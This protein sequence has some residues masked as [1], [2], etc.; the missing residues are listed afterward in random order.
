MLN[1]KLFNKFS[2]IIIRTEE[3][4]VN[5]ILRFGDIFNKDNVLYKINSLIKDFRHNYE[6]T[7]NA[8]KCEIQ[9]DAFIKS[10]DLKG[11]N[12]EDS[13]SIIKMIDEDF[14]Q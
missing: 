11:Y 14:F 8:I 2:E 10:N 9:K 1:T 13:N 12:Q 3:L 7:E 5:I 6:N 4:D